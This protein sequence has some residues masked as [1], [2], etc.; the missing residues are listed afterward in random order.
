MTTSNTRRTVLSGNRLVL[1]RQKTPERKLVNNHK[2]IDNNYLPE[3]RTKISAWE[4]FRKYFQ[5]G[6]NKKFDFFRENF[7]FGLNS[8]GIILNFMAVVSGNSK[9]ISKEQCQKLDK[10]SEWFSK[11]IIPLSFGWNGIEAAVGNR[12]LEA[13]ARIVPAISFL[14]L[15]FHNLNI[16]T[17]VSSGLQYLFEL[18]RDRHGGKNPATHNIIENAKETLK[19]SFA[20]IKD[21]LTFNQTYEDLP[22]QISASFLLM[23]SIGGLIF[24]PKERDSFLARFFGNMR[25]IGGLVA[26]WKLIFND[27]ADNARRAFDLRFVGSLCS[28]ASIL[29]IIMRWVNPQIAR[30]LNHIAIAIDDFGL[31]YWAQCS[32]RDNDEQ[33]K[34]TL[35]SE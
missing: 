9:M 21:I 22:K 6:S 3:K 29:N 19:T 26:D 16:A 14:F 33:F 20:I 34:Q 23:G 11:Y 8:I 7:T 12:G 10:S 5:D 30:A 17:G 31:T 32:K 18:V 28:T 24:A 27:I 35:K 13:F 4:N 2:M 15:P 25:N 1:P